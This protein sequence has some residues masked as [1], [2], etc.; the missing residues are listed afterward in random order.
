MK[1]ALTSIF[2]SAMLLASANA[3]FA[4]SFLQASSAEEQLATD[5]E[6]KV[7]TMSTTNLAN[8]HE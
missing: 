2:A 1:I 4:T 3:S 5:I 8:A 7:V 6:P